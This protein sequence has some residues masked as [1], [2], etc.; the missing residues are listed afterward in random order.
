MQLNSSN[1]RCIKAVQD[2]IIHFCKKKIVIKENEYTKHKLVLLDEA[3]N[4]TPKAQQLI[5]N[6]MEKYIHT[7]R[8]AFTCNNSSDIIESIQSRCIIFRYKRLQDYQIT[9]KLQNICEIEN[10][11]Y[12]MDGLETLTFI[13]QGDLRQAIN[14]L[15]LTFSSYN[16]VNKES[17]YNLCDEP[18]PYIIKN[19]L[20]SC[21]NNDIKE[22]LTQLKNLFDKGY[23]SS[24][25][26]ISI[27]NVLKSVKIEEIDEQ[28]KIKFMKEIAQTCIVIS[29]GID[30]Y[31]QLTGCIAKMALL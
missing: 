17:I 14:N 13:S 5:N 12:D 2:S 24:D 18:Q 8:F 6:L 29:R 16:K 25:I 4:M 11:E 21:K 19:I 10:I 1:D 15:Q 31:I 7:T 3:D 28:I 22:S 9:N 27:L 30:S 23:S 20:I 26:A